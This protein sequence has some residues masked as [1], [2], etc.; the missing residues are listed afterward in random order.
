MIDTII[1]DFGDIFINLN[2]EKSNNEFKKLGLHKWN[3][4]LKH[5]NK[6]FEIGQINEQSFLE[7]F[8]QYT[9]NA[10]LVQIKKAWNDLLGDFPEYRLMFLQKLSKNYRLF[11]LS[12]TDAIHIK[13]FEQSVG[14]TFANEFYECFE[15]VYFSYEVKMRKPD[16]AVFAHLIKNHNLKVQNTL[17]VDDKAINTTAAASL[18][19]KIWNLQVGQEDV[20]NLFESTTPKIGTS[21]NNL[22]MF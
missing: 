12:N 15:K 10:N 3:N 8:L 20:I 2:Y 1:F 21:F 11:L 22:L 7:S 4:D 18:D 6:L 9:N 5:Q 17:F 13:H 19:I 14:A 16:E